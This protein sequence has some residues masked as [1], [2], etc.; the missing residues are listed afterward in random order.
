[1]ST[2]IDASGGLTRIRVACVCAYYCVCICAFLCMTVHFCACV[3]VYLCMTVHSV[4]DS[5]HVPSSGF[6]QHGGLDHP[7]FFKMWIRPTWQ[8]GRPVRTLQVDSSNVAAWTTRLGPFEWIRPTWRPGLP[9]RTLQVNS[10]NMAAWTSRLGP[11]KWIRPTDHTM[12]Y[13]ACTNN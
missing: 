2:H 10:S 7:V 13:C 3:C 9:V 11:F 8:P 1:M 4:H 5:V 6:I 12:V